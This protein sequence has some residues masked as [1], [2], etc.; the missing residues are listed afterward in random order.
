MMT[1][2]TTDWAR[3]IVHWEIQA[4]DQANMRDF[5]VQMFNWDVAEGP[6]SAVKAGIG[7]VEA[8]GFEGHILPG[9][10]SRVLLWIQV[11]NLTA[12]MS[13]AEQLGG[14]I[15]TQPFDVPGGPTLAVIADPEGNH[16]RLVQQ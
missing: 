12:S 4:R 15:I 5:Y 6:I 16:I 2:E 10:G 13:K 8:D 11:L 14:A 7:G 9:D 1:N 3:P